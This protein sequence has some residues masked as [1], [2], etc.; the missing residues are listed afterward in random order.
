MAHDGEDPPSETTLKLELSKSGTKFW[1]NNID[2]VRR[3]L[4]A[5]P[6]QRPSGMRVLSELK[7]LT[8]CGC[9]SPEVSTF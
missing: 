8:S 6:E 2:M 3:C 9:E 7:A 5:D 1:E 4:V